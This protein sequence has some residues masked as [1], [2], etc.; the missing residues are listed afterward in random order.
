M[1]TFGDTLKQ[2]RAHKGVTLKEAE[3]ATRI[4]RNHLAALEDE[5][6]AALPPL[7]YQRGIVRNYAMYLDLDP[8]RILSLFEDAR[9][10]DEPRSVDGVASAPP[11]NMPSHWA[12][13]FAIIAF[14]VVLSA[15]VFAWTYSAFVQ[16]GEEP[17]TPTEII[18]TVTPF[19]SD[20]ALPTPTPTTPIPTSEPTQE[21][22]ATQAT[23]LVETGRPI[24]TTEAGGGDNQLDQDPNEPE[25][26]IDT[27]SVIDGIAIAAEGAEQTQAPET[28]ATVEETS[29][30]EDGV[31]V[32]SIAVTAV[33]TIS[34]SIVADGV[35]V[36]EGQL[37]PGETSDWVDGSEFE[38]MTSSGANTMFINTCSDV[39]F[40][41]GYEPDQAYYILQADADSCAPNGG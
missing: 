4:N 30:A 26:E 28:E 9:G 25:A 6:F 12:P 19:A 22:T 17:G 11:V 40:N 41:M 14:A 34:V 13:N 21:A 36:W 33:D 7:I 32:T 5:N 31:Y 29:Q 23:E 24:P 1:A 38:V 27:A 10:G 20:V 16:P 15:I 3:Q 8:S 18:A 39:P 35:P 2:A 37:G